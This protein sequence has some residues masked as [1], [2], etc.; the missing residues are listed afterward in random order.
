MKTSDNEQWWKPLAEFAGHIFTA[1]AIFLMIASASLLISVFVDFVAKLGA[2]KVVITVMTYVE[3]GLL[4]ADV[5]LFA[6]WIII[7]AFLSL[8]RELKKWNS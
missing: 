6:T 3:Y 5:L 7:S 2:N 4:A 1:T 8:K